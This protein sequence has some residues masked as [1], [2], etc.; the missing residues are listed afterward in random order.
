MGL[1]VQL[2]SEFGRA[3]VNLKQMRRLALLMGILG[4]LANSFECYGAWMM[5][6][7]AR[8]CC[9]SGHCSP[10]NH[11]PCCK[12]APSGSIQAFVSQHKS[13]VSPTVVAVAVLPVTDSSSASTFVPHQSL[14]GSDISPPLGFR[15]NSLPLLI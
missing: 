7:Q 5:S 15:T 12:N 6:K 13:E 3:M 2:T 9:N 1:R 10:A 11:D 4:L 8:D 14:G